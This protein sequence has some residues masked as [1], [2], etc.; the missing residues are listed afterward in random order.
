MSYGGGGES[1]NCG[2]LQQVLDGC[3]FSS[4]CEVWDSAT[5]AVAEFG[6]YRM[7]FLMVKYHLWKP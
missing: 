7:V 5:A 3:F 1:V 4:V 2:V 6:R